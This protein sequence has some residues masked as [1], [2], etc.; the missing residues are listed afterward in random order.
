[1]LGKCFN[2]SPAVINQHLGR[3]T[4]E[5]AELEVTQNDMQ[6]PHRES[7][8]SEAKEEQLVCSN[9]SSCELGPNHPF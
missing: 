9:D 8:Q 7:G 3:S 1:N 4:N 6:D 2:F 5:V